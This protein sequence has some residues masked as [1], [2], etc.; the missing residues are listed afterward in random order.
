MKQC[1]CDF[2]LKDEYKS[3]KNDI[4]CE[5]QSRITAPMHMATLCQRSLF[6]QPART[7]LERNSVSSGSHPLHWPI[8]K[9]R[10]KIRSHNGLD[11]KAD[12]DL[13]ST[14]GRWKML[15]ENWRGA[16]H[17][18]GRAK[19]NCLEFKK[20]QYPGL[21]QT[22]LIRSLGTGPTHLYFIKLLK[23][24]QCAATV[25][26][27]MLVQNST[28]KQKNKSHKTTFRHPEYHPHPFGVRQ[29]LGTHTLQK[30]EVWFFYQWIWVRNSMCQHVTTLGDT[31]HTTKN[32]KW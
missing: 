6:C 24:L 10:A 29:V 1:S 19:Y 11:L 31:S 3:S 8:C 13:A 30:K 27:P 26:S 32:S 5:D 15:V 12:P 2:H 14:S 25:V 4:L 22:S 17:I 28:H 21:T 9:S 20:P 16:R 7:A 23:C 18:L